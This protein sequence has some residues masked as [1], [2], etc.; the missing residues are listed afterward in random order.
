M[1]EIKD[2]VKELSGGGRRVAPTT[3]NKRDLGGYAAFTL[4]LGYKSRN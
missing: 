4:I 3:A 1:C 2:G